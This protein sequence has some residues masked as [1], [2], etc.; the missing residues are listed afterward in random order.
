[1]ADKMIGVGKLVDSVQGIPAAEMRTLWAVLQRIA[2][3]L[4]KTAGNET[5]LD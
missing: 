4:S 5:V 1:M 2:D 3:N